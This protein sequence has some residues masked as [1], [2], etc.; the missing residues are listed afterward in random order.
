MQKFQNFIV[1]LIFFIF[2]IAG[3]SLYSDISGVPSGTI[4][5]AVIVNTILLIP[6]CVIYAIINLIKRKILQKKEQE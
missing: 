4:I 6:I 1:G 5:A 2:I 3:L